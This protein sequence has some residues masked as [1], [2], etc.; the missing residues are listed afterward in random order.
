MSWLAL[1]FRVGKGKVLIT[2]TFFGQEDFSSI[3]GWCLAQSYQRVKPYRP[4]SGRRLLCGISPIQSLPP[5]WLRSNWDGYKNGGF[6]I[7]TPKY[8]KLKPMKR[9]SLWWSTKVNLFKV[10][11]WTKGSSW[12][13]FLWSRNILSWRLS[14]YPH[15]IGGCGRGHCFLVPKA[16]FVSTSRSM[17]QRTGL[18][19]YESI[20]W[21]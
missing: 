2:S 14:I 18:S 6:S 11:L 13:I 8:V 17:V 15:N 7:F 4:Q 5:V 1:V 9:V 19:L 3:H 16:F 20:T 21:R 10:P 12:F